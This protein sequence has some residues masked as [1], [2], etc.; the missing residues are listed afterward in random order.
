M[1]LQKEMRKE[2]GKEQ[3]QGGE[4]EMMRD[5]NLS[6]G[7]E[8]EEDDKTENKEERERWTRAWRT[9]CHRREV[10]KKVMREG[11]GRV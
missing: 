4:R 8:Q 9:P 6:Q 1:K 2:G 10:E 3:V 7:G 5:G 11:M